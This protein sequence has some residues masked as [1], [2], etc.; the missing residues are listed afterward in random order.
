[1]ER[2][3]LDTHLCVGGFSEKLIDVPN[4][5]LSRLTKCLSGLSTHSIALT[6]ENQ[7]YGGLVR[8]N[9]GSIWEENRAK[10]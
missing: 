1:M 10:G 6:Q 4:I 8:E 5:A 9:T 2:G 7:A 3:V